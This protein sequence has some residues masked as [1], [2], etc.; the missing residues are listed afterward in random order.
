MSI[1]N[2]T[3]YT[4]KEQD[5]IKVNGKLANFLFSFLEIE[6]ALGHDRGGVYISEREREVLWQM[7]SLHA[8][9]NISNISHT[10]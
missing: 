7:N 9:K 10:S 1:P 6:A 5:F 3:F 4:E 2:F 8:G